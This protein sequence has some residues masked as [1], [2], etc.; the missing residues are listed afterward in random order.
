MENNK[1][2]F[3]KFSFIIFIFKTDTPIQHLPQDSPFWKLRKIYLVRRYP[4]NFLL[5][6]FSK[7]HNISRKRRGGRRNEI[8]LGSS[9]PSRT[10]LNFTS[11]KNTNRDE[12]KTLVVLP[13]LF[14]L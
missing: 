2:Y 5:C 12:R 6:F 8:K 11:T 14:Q 9:P 7:K 13:I 3:K 10:P 1:N 4:R